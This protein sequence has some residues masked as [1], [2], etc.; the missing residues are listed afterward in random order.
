MGSSR[1]SAFLPGFRILHLVARNRKSRKKKITKPLYF[2][3]S[4]A[5][6]QANMH[7]TV[8]CRW[9]LGVTAICVFMGFFFFNFFA[10][11]G[12]YKKKPRKEKKKLAKALQDHQ[13]SA[14]G[15]AFSAKTEE[16]QTGKIVKKTNCILHFPAKNKNKR[17][18]S[19]FSL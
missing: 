1:A 15:S 3:I 4:L 14:F 13:K 8:Q 7:L 17:Y 2:E 18:G 16:T 6:N 19:A 11:L 10:F 12:R 5:G 9:A